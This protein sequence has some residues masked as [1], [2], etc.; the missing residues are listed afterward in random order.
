MGKVPDLRAKIYKIIFQVFRR[1]YLSVLPD[2]P[3]QQLGTYLA[4]GHQVYVD[5]LIVAEDKKIIGRIGGKEILEFLVNTR[6]N[7][8]TAI[9]ASDIMTE[10]TS[11]VDI[12]SS[13]DDLLSLFEKTKFALHLLQLRKA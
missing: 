8:F 4:I 11:S 7:D 3:F 9:K 5:G 10:D 2:T 13:L 12:D 1:P 6:N